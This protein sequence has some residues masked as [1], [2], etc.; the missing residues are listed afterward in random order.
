M[1]IT[2]GGWIIPLAITVPFLWLAFKPYKKTGDYDF[3]AIF[4]FLW[5][6]PIGPV[7]A[8]YFAIMYWLK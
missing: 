8:I 1:T 4:D 3:G 5:L 7:W 6:I 2:I